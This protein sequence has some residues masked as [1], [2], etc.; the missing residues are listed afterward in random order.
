MAAA[1]PYLGTLIAGAGTAYTVKEGIEAKRKAEQQAMEQ[2]GLIKKQEEKIEAERKKQTKV[3][4]ERRQRLATRELL[5]G[6]ET[7]L[8]GTTQA[9]LLGRS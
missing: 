4:Q 6:G 2:A 9:T 7:G 5:T 8:T 1:L 3:A